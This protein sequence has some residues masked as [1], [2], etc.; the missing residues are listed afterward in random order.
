MAVYVRRRRAAC[1]TRSIRKACANDQLGQ[2]SIFHLVVGVVAKLGQTSPQYLTAP[3]KGG[4]K[5]SEHRHIMQYLCHIGFGL[6]YAEIGEKSNRHRATVAEA[7]ETI[8]DRRDEQDFDRRLIYV[9]TAL[10][11]FNKHLKSGTG[12]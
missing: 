7:C 5:L 11:A 3:R 12:G 6:S 4:R 10:Q 8:E 9:E 2:L 1:S